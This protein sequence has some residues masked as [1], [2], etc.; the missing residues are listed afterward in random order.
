[1]HL[2]ELAHGGIPSKTRPVRVCDSFR[3]Q[4]IG[5]AIYRYDQ[6]RSAATGLLD[7]GIDRRGASYESIV[8]TIVQ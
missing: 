6:T 4:Y 8:D 7:D 2:F 3:R 5:I 1:M